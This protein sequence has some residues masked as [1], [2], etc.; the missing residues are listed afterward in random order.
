MN[1]PPLRQSLNP[2]REIDAF[3]ASG[4]CGFAAFDTW[5]DSSLDPTYRHILGRRTGDGNSVAVWG[6]LNPSDAGAVDDDPTIRRVIRFTRDMGKS[7]ALVVNVSD[8]IATDPGVLVA[9]DAPVSARWERYIVAAVKRAD[10]VILGWG[11]NG[12]KIPAR[13]GRFLYAVRTNFDGP[14]HCLR[15]TEKTK[16]PEHPLMLPASLRPMVYANA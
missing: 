1:L 10:I 5:I 14:L 3:I 7:I 12:S 11:A 16:Q 2:G 15:V 4:E 8:L 9:L 13:V 6:M